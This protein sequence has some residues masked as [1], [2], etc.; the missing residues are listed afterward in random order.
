MSE[1]EDRELR[2]L[3]NR[4]IDEGRAH[5]LDVVVRARFACQW[6]AGNDLH[7]EL[8]DEVERLRAR[9]SALDEA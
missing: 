4:A 7:R 8:A 3:V 9:L 5:E 6:G 2:D 1:D